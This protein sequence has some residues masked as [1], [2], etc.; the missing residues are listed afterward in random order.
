MAVF[1]SDSVVG[2]RVRSK[3]LVELFGEDF[4]HPDAPHASYG[5]T[6]VMLDNRS[7]IGMAQEV[8]QTLLERQRERERSLARDTE[9]LVSTNIGACV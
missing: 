8:R 3:D 6:M 7:L 9:R 2:G 4:I 5:G 1:E